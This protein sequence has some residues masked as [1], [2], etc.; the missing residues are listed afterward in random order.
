MLSI[1]IATLNE[2]KYLP[3]LLASI[4]RPVFTDYEV[5]V[6]DGSSQD[7]TREVAAGLGC[8]VVVKPT[9]S[10]GYQRNRG[11]EAAR[12]DLLLFLDADTVLPDE[13]FLAK[14]LNEFSQQELVVASCSAKPR[15]PA[16]R[17]Q[18]LLACSNL[19]LQLIQR[20]HP[21]VHVGMI[22]ATKKCHEMVGGFDEAPIMG[23][24]TAY[25]RRLSKLG[26]F[27]FLQS[28]HVVISMRRFEQEG[29][30]RLMAVGPVAEV[31]RRFGGKPRHER[32]GY[33]FGHYRRAPGGRGSGDPG[34]GT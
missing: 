13:G 33:R 17:Y 34:T 23:E 26:R 22:L 2:E 29:V 12:G 21:R 7:R 16:I 1:I 10:P 15:E 5:I 27:R 9:R 14:A 25:V 24:D 8:R 6:S 20:I 32:F 11:A 19:L 31:A 18:A 28:V 3:S 4:R 30:F